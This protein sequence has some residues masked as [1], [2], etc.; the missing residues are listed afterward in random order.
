MRLLDLLQSHAAS[1][2]SAAAYVDV[3]TGEALSWSELRDR[4]SGLSARLCPSSRPGSVVLIRCANGLDFPVAFLAALAAGCS[5]FP[6]SVDSPPREIRGI[7][8]RVNA[9]AVIATDSADFD[10]WLPELLLDPSTIEPSRNA[11]PAIPEAREN[12]RL[13]LL[14][15]GSTGEPKIICR[16]SDSLD[17]VCSQMCQSIGVR[18]GDRVL[19][20]VPLCHSYGIEHGLLAPV[21]AGATVHLCRGLDLPLIK[22]E[23]LASRITLLPGVPSMYEMLANLAVPGERFAE[24]RAAYS[25]GA[26]LPASVA[27]LVFDRCGIRVGQL[28]GASEIGSVTYSDPHSPSFDSASVGNPMPGVIIRITAGIDIH[29]PVAVNETGHVW[30]SAGSMFSGYLGESQSPLVDGF[31]PTGDLGRVDDNGNLFITGRVKLL[32]DVGGLKVNPLEVEAVLMQH[33]DIAECVVIP[34]RQSETVMRLKAIV[35]PRDPSDPPRIQE[36]RQ[37]ARA[38][39]ATYKVP[40]VFEVRETLPRTTTG[41]I[42]RHLVEA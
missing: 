17:A 19:A 25:A 33:P 8:E 6:L 18:A 34:V 21:W 27:A 26:P 15:S 40:R 1:N 5:A 13:M 30:I 3:T 41:K 11:F 35:I 37:F 4:V 14:S 7:A 22:R 2:P 10:G 20:T 9:S 28:Y 42:I 39:L 36:I 23:L 12:V 16:S 38:R 29:E 32:I 24:I 31:Y